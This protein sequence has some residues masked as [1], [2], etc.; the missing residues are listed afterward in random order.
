MILLSALVLGLLAGWGW[1]R[2]HNQPFRLP[3]LEFVWLVPV[4]FVPQLVVAYLPGTQH[5]L[6]ATLAAA[7]LPMSLTVFLAFIWVNRGLAGMPILLAGLV[8]NLVVIVI[9]G[10][11]MPISPET[12]SHL[13]G[14]D[15]VL[16]G[17]P[18]SRF[19]QK[20]I[21]LLPQDTRLAFLADRFL[22]PD[23]FPYHVAFSLG[24]ILVAVG[25]FWLL[26]SPQ[27]MPTLQRSES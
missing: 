17:P 25:V 1:A 13:P 5:L 10:G 19:G 7:A 26:A 2:R 12:A 16:S 14:G 4:A 11:W 6:P 23:W 15:A 8:L 9:N 18:G 22:L 3:D 24:D 20:D 21:L 27:S